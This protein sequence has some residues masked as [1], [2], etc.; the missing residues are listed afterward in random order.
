MADIAPWEIDSTAGTVTADWLEGQLFDTAP[1]SEV[2]AT[3]V[4][5]DD[6]VATDP[7]TRHEQLQA[8]VDAAQEG[9][10]IDVGATATADPYYV[11]SLSGADV[12]SLLL[13]L[14]PKGDRRGAVWAVLRSGSDATPAV[15]EGIHIWELE[16]TVL[17]RFAGEDRSTIKTQHRHEVT[18]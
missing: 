15:E 4:F 5:V 8:Y 16:L 17:Q 1:G 7:A 14:T 10:T 6:G 13:A 2:T 18:E 11:E 9:A 3:F 12:D